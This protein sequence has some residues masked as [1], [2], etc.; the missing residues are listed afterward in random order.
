MSVGVLGIQ[1][2]VAVGPQVS[3]ARGRRD[4]PDGLYDASRNG[5]CDDNDGGP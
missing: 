3:K 4:H 5:E 1:S 2:R